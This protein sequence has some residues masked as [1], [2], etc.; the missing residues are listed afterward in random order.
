MSQ[1]RKLSPEPPKTPKVR[2]EIG[3][4]SSV[5]GM[6]MSEKRERYLEINR[7]FLDDLTWVGVSALPLLIS[8]HRGKSGS[9]SKLKSLLNLK[10]CF[11]HS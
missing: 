9:F 11:T 8:V 5:K 3:G 7:V 1:R 10:K 2:S 4:M 6:K